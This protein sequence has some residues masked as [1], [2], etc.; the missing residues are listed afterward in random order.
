MLIYYSTRKQCET[1][2]SGSQ[3]QNQHTLAYGES[4]W[5]TIITDLS[6]VAGYQW[7]AAVSA[8]S[9]KVIAYTGEDFFRC[10]GNMITFPIYTNTDDFKKETEKSSTACV[11]ELYAEDQSGSV[12]HIIRIPI[13]SLRT[14]INSVPD[15]LL[16]PPADLSGITAGPEHILEGYQSVNS[17]GE[18]IRG[19]IPNGTVSDSNG[20]IIV[21]E[22]YHS[23]KEYPPQYAEVSSGDS[24]IMISNGYLRTPVEF[25]VSPGNV[26]VDG[27]LVSIL[28]GMLPAGEYRVGNAVPGGTFAPQ[29]AEQRIP[30]GS[31]LNNDIVIEPLPDS[32]V[33]E[34]LLEGTEVY[35]VKGKYTPSPFHLA[36]V[37]EYSPYIPA[38]PAQIGYDIASI[39]DPNEED[40]S[41]YIGVYSVTEETKVCTKFGRIFSSTNGK[42]LRAVNVMDGMQATDDSDP[43][44]IEWRFCDSAD[45]WGRLTGTPG[46]SGLPDS[47]GGWRNTMNYSEVSM[48]MTAVETSGATSAIPMLLKGATVTNFDAENQEWIV[49]AD[50]ITKTETDFEPEIGWIYLSRD[51]RLIGSAIGSSVPASLYVPLHSNSAASVT[52]QALTI[53][54]DFN[55]VAGVP[56]A[57]ARYVRAAPIDFLRENGDGFAVSF[58]IR[59]D[60]ENGD[61][62]I[63]FSAY[64]GP[65]SDGVSI[66]LELVMEYGRQLLIRGGSPNRNTLN[67]YDS[68]ID[69]WSFK[70]YKWYHLC[71]VFYADHEEVYA[72]GNLIWNKTISR[73][74]VIRQQ[75]SYNYVTI[76][77]RADGG[78]YN[79]DGSMAEFKYYSNVI[80]PAQVKAEANRC[81][82]MVES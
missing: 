28:P 6:D 48:N 65:W 36:I 13:L 7:H 66:G 51:T 61:S 33:P 67:N 70:T 8:H 62:R 50:N 22:G 46:T 78:G 2:L 76:A 24:W 21:S 69:T 10:A 17:D 40:F 68:R 57:N 23:R 80:S 16:R 32:L 30:A 19:T 37:T 59:R 4:E 49:K 3:T 53:D 26:I 9:G 1:D 45:G 63:L 35:G 43:T 38:Y 74:F 82:A 64:D 41:V 34:I 12:E 25:S 60:R 58:M 77:N 27:N 72:D 54:A 81:L 75:E 52:G 29:P 14:N 39:T 15:N 56:C 18:E 55:V 73:R 47:V 31:Y 42:F 44:Y 71:F 20:T 5:F 79:W 11:L